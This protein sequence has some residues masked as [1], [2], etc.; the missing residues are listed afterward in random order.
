MECYSK[1]YKSKLQLIRQKNVLKAKE[2]LK[3]KLYTNEISSID[4]RLYY[5]HQKLKR[6]ESTVQENTFTKIKVS[7]L[8]ISEESAHSEPDEFT[9]L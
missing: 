6:Y 7:I 5:I 1:L 3:H 8:T 4:N 9:T 2:K